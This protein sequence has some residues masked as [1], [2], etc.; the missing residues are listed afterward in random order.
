MNRPASFSARSVI[1]GLFARRRTVSPRERGFTRP[2]I[3]P[4][5][6]AT[7]ES[8]GVPPRCRFHRPGPALGRTYTETSVRSNQNG[9]AAARRGSLPL[10]KGPLRGRTCRPITRRARGWWNSQ[11]WY[12]RAPCSIVILAMGDSPLA[13]HI[14]FG[15]YGAR[16]HG[17]PRGT[18]DRRQSAHGQPIVDCSEGR[19]RMEARQLKHQ[20]VLHTAEQRAY[21][22]DAIKQVCLQG[23]WEL[24]QTA[25]GSDH[26]HVLL[27]SDRDPKAIRRWLKRW[28]GQAM[29]AR[30]PL[31]EG[32]SWWAKGGSAKY[33]WDQEYLCSVDEYLRSQRA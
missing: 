6:C 33:V 12:P 19:Q 7:G 22:Q 15:T 23:E 32:Q 8:R 21:A 20:P 24:I 1:R 10:R 26:V 14:T 30:W 31:S 11:R 9:T 3:S 28:L 2:S 18:V 13:Y 4:P 29:S 17:D 5:I 27:S 25:C 16:L